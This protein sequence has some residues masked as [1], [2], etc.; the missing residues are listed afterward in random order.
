MGSEITV[1]RRALDAHR[2]SR[3]RF[4]VKRAKRDGLCMRL[5]RTRGT[6]CALHLART[7]DG[8]YRTG[9]RGDGGA[10]CPAACVRSL[11]SDA[12]E[13][14]CA[15][16][17]NDPRV[18]LPVSDGRNRVLRGLRVWLSAAVWR[19]QTWKP[20]CMALRGAVFLAG[21]LD[22]ALVGLFCRAGCALSCVS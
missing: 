5:V 8:L 13:G 12:R 17:A 11:S 2:G 21:T 6:F 20:K 16:R 1:E 18:H 19:R 14:W 9:E 3:G 22:A 10:L 4:D 15:F 7:V